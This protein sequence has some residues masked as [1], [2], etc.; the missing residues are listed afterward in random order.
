LLHEATRA[1]GVI[2]VHV[3]KNNVVDISHVEVLL[4]E[5]IQKKRNTA[6]DAGV[7]VR[8]ATLFDDQVARVV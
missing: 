4:N 2:E 8:R 6:V 5:S 3:S 1:A 7:D